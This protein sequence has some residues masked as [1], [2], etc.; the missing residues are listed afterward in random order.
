[1]EQTRLPFRDIMF[2]LF[3]FV[4]EWKVSE[5]YN[6]L[7]NWRGFR[8]DSTISWHSVIDY[9][10]CFREVTEIISSH[11]SKQLGGP[12]KTITLNDTFFMKRKYIRGRRTA[13]MAQTVLGI[14][15]KEDHEGLLFL[16]DGKKKDLWPLIK[17]HIH[18]DTTIICTD[19]SRKSSA[20]SVE[21][22]ILKNMAMKYY[23]RTR[24]DPIG[25]RNHGAQ[26]W[27]F[28]Q[29]VI[30]VYPGCLKPGLDLYQIDKVISKNVGIEEATEIERSIDFDVT[31]FLELD[32]W[33]EEGDEDWEFT[34]GPAKKKKC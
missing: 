7:V 4:K 34:S 20:R 3:A 15:C 1:M 27:Q 24:L 16:V 14:F 23:R 19:D 2:I 5:I 29:D 31:E 9:Y 22:M 33:E 25:K 17:E 11:H 8:E 12:N 6:N 28:I 32:M 30:E 13:S 26:V 10:G 18:P 21:K